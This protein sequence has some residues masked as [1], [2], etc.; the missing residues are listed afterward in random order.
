[1]FVIVWDEKAGKDLDVWV[2]LKEIAPGDGPI[3]GEIWETGQ[4]ITFHWE[5]KKTVGGGVVRAPPPDT[6]VHN[7][8]RTQ[9]HVPRLRPHDCHVDAKPQKVP[10][11]DHQPQAFVPRTKNQR[12]RERKNRVKIMIKMLQD[13]VE[14]VQ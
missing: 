5:K 3:Q 6:M 9:D 8:D 10:E 14:D 4:P 12:R 1:M 11:T 2:D 13:A 7:I